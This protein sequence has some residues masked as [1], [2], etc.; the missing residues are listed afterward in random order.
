MG[1]ENDQQ[2]RVHVLVSG[3]VQ[4]VFF[5]SAIRNVAEDVGLTGYVRNLSDGRVEAE[6]QGPPDGV[7]QALRFCRQGPSQARV[8][9]VEVAELQPRDHADGFEVQ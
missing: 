4:G 6:F 3:H 7:D 2:R 9:N 5:R 1:D 8:E